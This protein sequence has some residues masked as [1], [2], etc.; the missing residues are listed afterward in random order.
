ME[1]CG[2]VVVFLNRL[3]QY[4]ITSSIP[5]FQ[6]SVIPALHH[7]TTPGRFPP[8]D[9]TADGLAEP[10]AK[11][12]RTIR[13]N[14][15]LALTLLLSLVNL[16]LGWLA[17]SAVVL[18]GGTA[19]LCWVLGRAS[20]LGRRRGGEASPDD[21]PPRAA[22]VRVPPPAR[23]P[24][25]DPQD[26]DALVEQMLEQ[27][28]YALLLRP[29]IAANLGDDQFRRALAMLQEHS[30]LVPDGEVVLGAI[31]EFSADGRIDPRELSRA[32]ARTVAVRRCFLDRHPVTNRL[33]YEFVGAGGYEQMALWD[34]AVLPAV[35]DFVD[36]TGLPGPR[37]WENGC[38][39][40]GEEDLPVVGVSWYEAAACARWLGKRLP[41]DAEWVKAGAWPVPVA[42]A[43]L[44]RK[45]PWGETMD[46]QRTNLWGSGPGRIVPVGEFAEGASVGGVFQLIGNVWEWTAGAYKPTDHPSGE[47][48]LS[49]PL[50]NLRGGAFD[51][52]FDNQATC[53]FHSGENPLERKHNIGFRCAVGIC[54]LLLGRPNAAVEAFGA[55][56]GAPPPAADDAPDHEPA[57]GPLAAATAE[58]VLR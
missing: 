25:I 52:Y 54:D 12:M 23:R 8:F 14:P 13:N 48:T 30:S 21:R 17:G 16:L 36:R 27:G 43:R 29:Q 37:Y 58:E 24:K 26:A 6:Y 49:S 39:L 50:R 18:G 1:W 10:E 42:G 45:F 32:G 22:A 57:A 19:G 53:Q 40:P 20:W 44:Q 47:I 2:G 3:F 56:E 51:T 28:R 4:S 33:Y 55:D 11:T 38:Y 34:K 7:S 5:V 9:R 31:D 41:S 15:I 35:L 46:R